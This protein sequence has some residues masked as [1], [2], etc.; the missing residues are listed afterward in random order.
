MHSIRSAVADSIVHGRRGAIMHQT[1]TDLTSG[2]AMIGGGDC[3]EE[4]R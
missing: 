3:E 1:E 2:S 4:W